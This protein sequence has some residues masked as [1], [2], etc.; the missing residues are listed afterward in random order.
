MVGDYM[1]IYLCRSLTLFDKIEKVSVMDKFEPLDCLNLLC[2]FPSFLK[3]IL[4]FIF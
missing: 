1:Q 3:N 4:P 2:Y